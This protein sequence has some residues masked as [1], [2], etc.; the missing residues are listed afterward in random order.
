MLFDVFVFAFSDLVGLLFEDF[1]EVDDVEFVGVS[2]GDAGEVVAFVA[3]GGDLHEGVDAF[4]LL[5][6]SVDDH[7][8]EFG[9]ISP[10]LC[11]GERGDDGERD[12]G[13][14]DVFDLFEVFEEVVDDQGFEAVD[15]GVIGWSPHA[16]RDFSPGRKP[17]EGAPVFSHNHTFSVHSDGLFNGLGA[18]SQR[19]V[20]TDLS[21]DFW[22]C[23]HYVPRRPTRRSA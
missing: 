10:G 21:F 8:V 12:A 18:G 9:V 7:D 23:A 3:F 2:D 15:G 16:D 6:S 4:S 17:L 14:G 19:V 22:R 11:E 13:S 5:E 20:V 1:G